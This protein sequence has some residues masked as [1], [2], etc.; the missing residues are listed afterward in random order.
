MSYDRRRW[1]AEEY[2]NVV[3]AP[4][5]AVEM[6]LN[7]LQQMADRQEQQIQTQQQ[8]LVAKEQRL[9]YLRQQEYL[10]RKHQ[11][12]DTERRKQLERIEIQEQK[13][14]R[15]QG[16]K[17][18]HLQRIA[19]NDKL[20][21]ELERMKSIFSAKEK[22]LMAAVAKVEEMSKQ[23]EQIRSHNANEYSSEIEKL[24]RELHLRN[25]LNEQNNAKLACKRNE[26]STKKNEMA[27]LDQRIEE[28]QERLKKKKVAQ[29]QRTKERVK[30][31]TNIAAVEP[32]MKKIENN[33][34]LIKGDE[35]HSIRPTK[36]KSSSTS[37]TITMSNLKTDTP[38][39]GQ[40]RMTKTSVSSLPLTNET[41][42]KHN[43][44]S[45]NSSA[46]VPKPYAG[47]LPQ[48]SP[49]HALQPSPDFASPKTSTPISNGRIPKQPPPTAPR[50]RVNRD[51]EL[52]TATNQPSNSETA[53]TGKLLSDSVEPHGRDPPSPASSGASQTSNHSNGHGSQ[54]S[55]Q[56]S[57]SGYV[58]ESKIE[59]DVTLTNA[60]DVL[61]QAPMTSSISSNRN[62]FAPRSVIANAYMNKLTASTAANY[63]QNTERLY[64]DFY[65]MLK[66]KKSENSSESEEINVSAHLNE[67]PVASAKSDNDTSPQEQLDGN[68][69]ATRRRTSSGTVSPSECEEPNEGEP[70]MIVSNSNLRRRRRGN[71]KS[72]RGFGTKSRRVSFDPLALLLDASLEGELELVMRSAKEVPDVSAPNDEG[73]TALHNAICAGHLEIVEFLVKFGANVNAP[74]SD[75]WTPL[76]CAASCNNL[77][78]VKFLVENGACVFATTVSDQETAADKCEQEEDNFDGCSKYLYDLQEKL[79]IINNGEV[80]AAFDYDA[81]HED[82]LD[83]K[84]D[85]KLIVI[86]KG[87]D[88]EKDW[89]WVKDGNK[90]GYV[91]RNLLALHCRPEP[92]REAGPP[93]LLASSALPEYRGSPTTIDIGD[94]GLS[95]C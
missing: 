7:E 25:K 68:Y 92:N 47:K 46:Y 83:M 95:R 18:E 27:F 21:E 93:F 81:Q 86:R 57:S 32:I 33:T 29:N 38:P 19:T 35:K 72:I 10:Q 28:M 36:V 48:N 76:H 23:L 44:F 66:E 87:D 52:I 53:T 56:T 69:K 67:E 82:E 70:E 59:K 63:K 5:T 45:P 40:Q 22:E 79:G 26:L 58:S 61:K 3:M 11:N 49:P 20:R 39:T 4:G 2:E 71:L 6:S 43:G 14:S 13:L 78:I 51:R 62:R 31:Q 60:L 94:E 73:I 84:E 50:L 1:K 8:M 41:E 80:F 9:K 37:S 77:P 74:D 42:K 65:T 30:S 85:Q 75:G 55:N 34:N 91:P 24:K 90:K 89:W 88:Q 12:E 54:T 64:S 17:G 15:I 16:L